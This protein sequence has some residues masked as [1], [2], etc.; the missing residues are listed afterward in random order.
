MF[1]VICTILKYTEVTNYSIYSENNLT[2]IVYRNNICACSTLELKLVSSVPICMSST[3]FVYITY[4][5]LAFL[6]DVKKEN[7]TRYW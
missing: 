4:V 5:L 7:E 3:Q 1:K 6:R 2:A